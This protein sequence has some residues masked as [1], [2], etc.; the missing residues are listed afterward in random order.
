[1]ENNEYDTVHSFCNDCIA[2]LSEQLASPFCEIP[3]GVGG[4]GLRCPEVGC[5]NVILLSKLIICNI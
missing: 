1:L 4:V 5:P 2:Q 3:L